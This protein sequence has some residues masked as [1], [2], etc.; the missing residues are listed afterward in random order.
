MVQL[1]LDENSEYDSS[2][3]EDVEPKEMTR[4]DLNEVAAHDKAAAFY[5]KAA[6]GPFSQLQTMYTDSI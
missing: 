3:N 2:D 1:I 5:C 6:A 4:D